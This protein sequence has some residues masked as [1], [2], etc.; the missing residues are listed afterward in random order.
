MQRRRRYSSDEFFKNSVVPPATKCGVQQKNQLRA[1]SS[2]AMHSDTGFPS[3][4]ARMT[5]LS[6][7]S[8]LDNSL[9]AISVAHL[10]RA[11][12]G[13]D[14]GVHTNQGRRRGDGLE[15][16]QRGCACDRRYTRGQPYAHGMASDAGTAVLARLLLLTYFRPPLSTPP[17][18]AVRANR[19][20]AVELAGGAERNRQPDANALNKRRKNKRTHS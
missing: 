14:A 5:D 3:R 9:C 16:T 13:S 19:S 18:A 4:K 7:G 1:P 17:A 10:A 15:L 11:A 6:S 12:V 20:A 2:A 8:W